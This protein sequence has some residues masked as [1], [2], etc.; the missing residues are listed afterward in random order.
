[1]ALTEKRSVETP[2]EG[3]PVLKAPCVA[4]DR[5]HSGAARED[6][7]GALPLQRTRATAGAVSRV[8]PWDVAVSPL[9]LL[10]GGTFCFAPNI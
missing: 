3:R 1:M 4:A 5:Y 2:R 8:E 10:R 9:N 6:R 7:A